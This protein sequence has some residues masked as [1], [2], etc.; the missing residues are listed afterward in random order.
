MHIICLKTVPGFFDIPFRFFL[1]YEENENAWKKERFYIK[2]EI[3][4]KISFPSRNTKNNFKRRDICIIIEKDKSEIATIVSD[5]HPKLWKSCVLPPNARASPLIVKSCYVAPNY[6]P[7]NH[8]YAIPKRKS[9]FRLR[10]SSYYILNWVS[11][12][13]IEW[14]QPHLNLSPL[15]VVY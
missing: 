6:T 9:W 5:L 12:V 3:F 15:R 7:L 14:T 8:V 2:R 1:C 4:P 11:P 10:L 13:N